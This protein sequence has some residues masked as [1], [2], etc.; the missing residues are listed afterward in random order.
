VSLSPAVDEIPR[1][2]VL[3]TAD[4]AIPP[5]LQRYMISASPC[6][7]VVELPVDHSP[8]I[9]ATLPLVDALER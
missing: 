1:S 3:C 4:R 2:Y 6:E 9:S 7:D 8:W 5:P